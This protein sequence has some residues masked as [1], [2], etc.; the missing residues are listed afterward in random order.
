MIKSPL[1]FVYDIYHTVKITKK[2]K[3]HMIKSPLQ[4]VYDIYHTVKITKNTKNIR[5]NLHFS[6]FMISIIQ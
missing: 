6:L 3:K 4:F 2:H 1:Q 5:L